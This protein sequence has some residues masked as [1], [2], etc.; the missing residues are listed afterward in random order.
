M[1][2]NG[3]EEVVAWR[4]T[5]L[6]DYTTQVTVEFLEYLVRRRNGKIAS[7]MPLAENVRTVSRSLENFSHCDFR[8]ADNVA[9]E[10]DLHD[11]RPLRV[12]TSE[13]GRPRR[14]AKRLHIKVDKL[15]TLARQPAQM[16]RLEFGVSVK[17]HIPKSL[18]IRK[19]EDHV[20]PFGSR[21][22]ERDSKKEKE[23]RQPIHKLA[24]Q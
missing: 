21:K 3:I 15:R 5:Y 17:A 12:A 4:I 20:G 16:R 10:I 9:A 2:K 13:Q 8:F 14:R 1:T 7:Q 11:S 22:C 24:Y 6:A 19:D 18:V 23:E